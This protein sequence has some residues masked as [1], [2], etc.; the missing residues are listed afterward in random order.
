VSPEV[1]GIEEAFA[2]GLDKKGVGV[3]GGVIVQKKA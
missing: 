2:I 3:E 1:G